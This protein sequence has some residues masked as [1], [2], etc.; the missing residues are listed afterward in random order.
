VKSAAGRIV[1]TKKP[2]TLKV[3]GFRNR[4]TYNEFFKVG[5]GL[6]PTVLLA[7]ILI[8]SPV[9]G[10]RPFLAFLDLTVKVP[11]LGYA[12][13]FSF[14]IAFEIFSK[15]ASTTS[16]ANLFVRLSSLQVLITALISSSLVKVPPSL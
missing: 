10:F 3:G 12:N 2:P 9:R 11:K 4:K 14:L 8:S 6:K 7:L 5:A 16:P 15:A 1:G 13:R